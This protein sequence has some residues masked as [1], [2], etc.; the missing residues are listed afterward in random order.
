[1]LVFDSPL[2]YDWPIQLEFV[3]LWCFLQENKALR[4][5]K[6]NQEERYMKDIFDGVKEGVMQNKSMPCSTEIYTTTYSESYL[7]IHTITFIDGDIC[8]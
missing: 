7:N 4:Q 1:M 3:K 5:K 6:L 2:F 8:N